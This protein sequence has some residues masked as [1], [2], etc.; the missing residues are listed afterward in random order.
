[1][2]SPASVAQFDAW[3]AT[4]PH[5]HKIITLGN[6]DTA[7]QGASMALLC[8]HNS[9]RMQEMFCAPWGCSVHPTMPTCH[10]KHATT[11]PDTTTVDV[12][13]SNGCL[14]LKHGIVL[15]PRS[16]TLLHWAAASPVRP[17]KWAQQQTTNGYLQLK[18]AT[19]ECC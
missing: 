19:G 16:L 13:T 5:A 18:H 8:V 10:A 17:R 4:L 14:R 15:L 12:A 11:T 9:A 1:M 3:L 6:M 2:Y 7:G